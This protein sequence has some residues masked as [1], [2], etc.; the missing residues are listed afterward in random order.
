[1]HKIPPVSYRELPES[2]H[3]PSGTWRVDVISGSERCARARGL[4]S[5]EADRLV[6]V[7]RGLGEVAEGLN[8]ATR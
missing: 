1:M 4:T 6:A 8:T 7:L 3:S 5:H 2:T